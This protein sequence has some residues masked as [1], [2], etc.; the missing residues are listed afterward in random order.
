MWKTVKEFARAVGHWWWA[1]TIDWLVGAFL[2]TAQSFGMAMSL[3]RWIPYLIILSGFVVACF[4]AFH[5]L[6]LERDDA[7]NKLYENQPN[8]KGN[9]MQIG[10]G[11]AGN[12]AFGNMTGGILIKMTITNRGSPSVARNFMVF[13][14]P[15]LSEKRIL[16]LPVWNMDEGMPL[17]SAGQTH[18]EN[19]LQMLRREY[20]LPTVAMTPIPR[21]GEIFGYLSVVFPGMTK[22][23][24]GQIGNKIIVEFEDVNE[25]RVSCEYA[26]IGGYVPLGFH[27]SELK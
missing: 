26:V 5:R 25:T 16:G 20:Y 13:F 3:P 7:T 11:T 2:G 4:V 14:Q 6:R 27:P 12:P 18:A 1:V 24:L 23:E 8:F 22:E 9:L 10:F 21:G 17:F 19:P 15:P